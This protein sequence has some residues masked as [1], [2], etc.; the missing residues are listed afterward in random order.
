MELIATTVLAVAFVYALNESIDASAFMALGV[1]LYFCLDAVK[2]GVR[3]QNQ[4]H[5][6]EGAFKRIEAI[7]YEESNIK[8]PEYPA[9]PQK[10]NGEVSFKNVEFSYD[11]VPALH[12]IE[13]TRPAGTVC[14]LVWLNGAGKSTCTKLIPRFYGATLVGISTVE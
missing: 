6:A 11:D 2:Q 10:L 5:R 1:A 8:E 14:G 13:I 3:I 7:L 12:D 9:D 4:A